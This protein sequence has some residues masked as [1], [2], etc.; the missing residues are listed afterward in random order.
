MRKCVVIDENGDIYRSVR[1]LDTY[2]LVRLR[3]RMK[4]I[5]TTPYTT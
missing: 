5:Y 3:D 2:A 4:G 1:I